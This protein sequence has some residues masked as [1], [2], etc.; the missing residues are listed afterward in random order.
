MKQA[1]DHAAQPGCFACHPDQPLLDLSASH[2]PARWNHRASLG[3]DRT[4]WLWKD[5][6]GANFWDASTKRFTVPP[7][8]ETFDAQCAACHFTGFSIDP[9]TLEATAFETPSGIPWKTPERRVEG[10]LACEV[11]HGPGREHRAA[12]LS[13]RAGQFIVHPAC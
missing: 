4:R 11:C 9:K 10:N 2:D 5:E 12:A 6:R 13:G 8:K 3:R 7:L 1:D